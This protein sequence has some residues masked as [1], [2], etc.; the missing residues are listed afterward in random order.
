[1]DTNAINLLGW[2]ESWLDPDS[3]ML[4]YRDLLIDETLPWDWEEDDEW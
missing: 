2:E 3:P 4:D 1:M